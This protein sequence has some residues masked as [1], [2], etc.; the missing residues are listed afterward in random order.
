MPN[1]VI[2]SPNSEGLNL[3]RSLFE[4]VVAVRLGSRP[5]SFQVATAGAPAHSSAVVVR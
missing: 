4:E 3:D 5:W 1:V 2:G